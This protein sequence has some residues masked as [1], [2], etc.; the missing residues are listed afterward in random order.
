MKT[1]APKTEIPDLFR[2][3]TIITDS[4]YFLI[5]NKFFIGSVPLTVMY[6]V[7]YVVPYAYTYQLYDLNLTSPTLIASS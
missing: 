7:Q 6:A 3:R 1:L 5:K 4:N 2:L